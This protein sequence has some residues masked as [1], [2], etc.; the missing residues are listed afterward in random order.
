M[1]VRPV[2]A[3]G[4]IALA[5][6]AVKDLQ[7]HVNA[8][9]EAPSKSVSVFK[10][11]QKPRGARREALWRRAQRQQR[12]AGLQRRWWWTHWAAGLIW[13]WGQL[14]L[15]R[16]QRWCRLPRLQCMGVLVGL[17]QLHLRAA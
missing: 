1:L 16:L 2:L 4:V 11:A 5:N 7:V 8:L 14:S 3:D 13:A 12:L 9:T 6:R 17:N 15:Q 10:I